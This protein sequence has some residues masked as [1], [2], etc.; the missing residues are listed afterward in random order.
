MLGV[1]PEG[2]PPPSH[3][4]PGFKIDESALEIGVKVLAG[5]AARLASEIVD[6]M[7]LLVA[8]VVGLLAG[9]VSGGKLGNVPN[10]DFR[11]PWFVVAALIVRE[12][13]VL[14]SAQP[15]STASSTCTWV[16]SPPSSDGR[17]WHGLRL[18]G[19]MD[20]GDRRG[21]NLVV[22]VANGARMPV[23]PELAGH[24]ID[25]GHIGQYVSMGLRHQSGLA[26]RLDRCARRAWRGVQPRRHGDRDRY[27]AVVV[28]CDAT[29]PRRQ[30]LSWMK[31]QVV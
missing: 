29:G 3:H 18:R 28:F 16:P 12:A 17:A 1:M 24:L 19:V 5:S 30:Q 10:L 15:K 23:A 7:L 9:I 22:V 20:R 27:R 11:W 25:R 6:P 31:P 2:S 4:S 21:L 8:L 14:K 26:R 13:A